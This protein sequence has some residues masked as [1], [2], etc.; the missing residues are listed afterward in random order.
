MGGPKIMQPQSPYSD[1]TQRLD[2]TQPIYVDPV[3]GQ[4]LFVD[5]VTGQLR[6][7]SDTRPLPM[8]PVPYAPIYPPAPW[9]YRYAAP[10][11]DGRATASLVCSL[12]G[13]SSLTCWGAGAILGLIGALLGHSARRRIRISGEDGHG[14]ATAGIIC[15]WI[16]FGLGAVAAVFLVA[17]LYGINNHPY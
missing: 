9:G 4:Q 5:P 12:I 14:M 2:P 17:F 3:T 7:G 15:G 11:T 8:P 13:I 10:R 6:Y 16:A 1:P